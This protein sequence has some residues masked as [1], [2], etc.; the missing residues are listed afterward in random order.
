MKTSRIIA[1]TAVAVVLACFAASPVVADFSKDGSFK[2]DKQI[3]LDFGIHVDESWAQ[4][5]SNYSVFE[6]PDPDIRIPVESATLDPKR[7][8]VTLAFKDTLNQSAEYIVEVKEVTS[9]GKPIG[10]GRFLVKKSQASLMM[11]I[12]LGAMLINNFV[13]TKYLGL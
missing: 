13:F 10:S 3:E 1:I 4:E 12:I 11:G 8:R 6:K 7:L 2:K 9:E 5:L